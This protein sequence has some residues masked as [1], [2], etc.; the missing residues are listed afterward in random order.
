MSNNNSK[1]KSPPPDFSPS[2]SKRQRLDSPG[3]VGSPDDSLTSLSSPE[4]LLASQVGGFG[5][6]D[7][8]VDIAG[9]FRLNAGTGDGTTEGD[10]PFPDDEDEDEPEEGEEKQEPPEVEEDDEDEEEEEDYSTTMH[11]TVSAKSMPKHQPR[12]PQTD[13]AVASPAPISSKGPLRPTVGGKG[14]KG[15]DALEQAVAAREQVERRR[16]E[17]KG[18][19]TSKKTGAKTGPGGVRMNGSGSSGGLEDVL[20]TVKPEEEDVVV[21]DEEDAVVPVCFSL[22]PIL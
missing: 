15:E 1:R 11:H 18:K 6:T 14:K 19:G 20:K 21:L 5:S 4:E 9:L 13:S 8:V 3:V 7:D 12:P 17:L 16:V 22:N 2:Q 10:S